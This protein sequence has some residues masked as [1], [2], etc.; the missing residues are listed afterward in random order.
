MQTIFANLIN[1]RMSPTELV[2]EFGSFFPDR[3]GI[4]PPSDQKPDVRVV[5]NILVLDNLITALSGLSAQ[6]K[7]AQVEPKTPMPVGFV[8]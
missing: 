3:P 8:K 2:L 5:M 4:A 1:F 7:S 6:R